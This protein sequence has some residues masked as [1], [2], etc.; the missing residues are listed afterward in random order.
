MSAVPDS[1]FARDRDFRMILW[2]MRLGWRQARIP[3]DDHPMRQP[4]FIRSNTF[5]WAFM[6]A[7]VCAVFVMV[8]FGFIYWKIDDYLTARSDRVI[9]VEVEGI[10]GLSPERRL[11]AIDERLRQ[12]PR[13]VQL[14][15]IFAADGHRIAG[16]LESLPPHLRID[17]AAQGADIIR[18]DR[19]SRQ[20]HQV[21]RAVARRMQN[22]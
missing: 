17:A 5:H 14:A 1:F 3:G 13:G 15:A 12:D 18:T 10:A 9:T 21:V 2:G 4:Q 16:N 8:L 20:Q 11:E 7:G 19:N 22:G 6:V